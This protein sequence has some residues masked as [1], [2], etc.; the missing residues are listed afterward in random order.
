MLPVQVAKPEQT[1]QGR[2]NYA[3]EVAFAA[4]LKTAAQAGLKLDPVMGLMYLPDEA[5]TTQFQSACR[6]VL[7]SLASKS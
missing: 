7:A 6:A 3:T 2:A 1:D 4:L 5:V